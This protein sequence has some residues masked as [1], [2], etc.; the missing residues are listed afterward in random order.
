MRGVNDDEVDDFIALTKDKPVYVRFIE[1]MPL[2][3]A[4]HT[5]QRVSGDELLR[6]HPALVPAPS[7]YAGQP[8]SDYHLPGHL[9]RVGFIN[10]LSHRFCAD[11]NRIRVMS[12]G[13]LRPCLGANEEISLREAI[14]SGDDAV[15]TRAIAGAIGKKPATHCFD[16]AFHAEKTMS[17]IGG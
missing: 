3:D 10:P 6:T 17:R 9:G 4:D 14:D 8:S 16:A 12:D 15:L 7:M 11:C 5:D 2:G 1:Y 13:M